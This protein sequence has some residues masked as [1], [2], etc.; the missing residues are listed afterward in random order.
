MPDISPLRSP[1]RPVY[2]PA[3]GPIAVVHVRRIKSW[4]TGER[5]LL[6]E[7]ALVGTIRLDGPKSRRTR[8]QDSSE[9]EPRRISSRDIGVLCTSSET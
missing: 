1:R 7:D 8:F 2:V 9:V 3:D 5:V 4:F 6:L